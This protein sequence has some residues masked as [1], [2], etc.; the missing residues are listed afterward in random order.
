MR[1]NITKTIAIWTL[2]M[3]A[4]CLALLAGVARRQTTELR[5]ASCTIP[6]LDSDGAITAYNW[7]DDQ[8]IVAASGWGRSFSIAVIDTRSG[9]RTNLY[10]LMEEIRRIGANTAYWSIAP[11]AQRALLFQPQQHEHAVELIDLVQNRID[12]LKMGPK[13]REI[14]WLPDS[15][16]WLEISKTLNRDVVTV[17]VCDSN[18]I[19][20]RQVPQ[21]IRTPLGFKNGQFVFI[22]DGSDLN[23]GKF[24]TVVVD[25]NSGNTTTNHYEIKLAVGDDVLWAVLNPKDEQIALEILRHRRV[26]RFRSQQNFPFVT[27]ISTQ[28]IVIALVSPKYAK[29]KVVGRCDARDFSVSTTRWLPSGNALSFALAGKLRTSFC[30]GPKWNAYGA[31]K[32]RVGE[33]YAGS[34]TE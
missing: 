32:T 24:E 13:S 23:R 9:A 1:R 22:P 26:P 21:K 8:T 6:S 3:T 27:A 29:M 19:V 16:A 7:V 4:V 15:S 30:N 28:E 11:N 17:R 20:H 18:T 14:V 10:L 34:K 33:T 5:R 2:A 25:L 12:P 31:Q